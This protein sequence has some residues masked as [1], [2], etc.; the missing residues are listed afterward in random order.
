MKKLEKFCPE[1]LGQNFS[2]MFVHILGNAT[3]GWYTNFFIQKELTLCLASLIG[4]HL[5][6]WI[7]FPVHIGLDEMIKVFKLLL[8][9]L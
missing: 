1:Y 9:W 2:K 6:F 8:G 3:T 5:F 7:T 4:T